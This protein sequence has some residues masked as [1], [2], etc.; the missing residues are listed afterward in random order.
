LKDFKLDLT[1]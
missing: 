1:P